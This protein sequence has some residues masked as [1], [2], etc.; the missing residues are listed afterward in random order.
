M[1]ARRATQRLRA[2]RRGGSDVAALVVVVPLIL[3][4]V[5]MFVYAGRQGSASQ[6][7]THAAAVAAR[8]ASMERNAVAAQ[9]AA[10]AAASS[11]LE[12]AGQS[13]AGGAGVRVSASGWAPGGVVSVTVTCIAAGVAGLGAPARTVSGT[14]R[15][16]I[17][18][19]WGYDR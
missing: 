7:V 10:S 2:D 17:D 18:V 8:A 16:T 9:S 15:A 6:G 5:L 3:G 14:A 12:A 19:F 13:C 11:S 4:V 1:T